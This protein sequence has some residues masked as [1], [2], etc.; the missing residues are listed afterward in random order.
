MRASPGSPARAV[1]A[2]H[3]VP[4]DVFDRVAHRWRTEIISRPSIGEYPVYDDNFY[5]YMLEDPV[6]MRAYENAIRHAAPGGVV[7][8]IGAGAQAPLS[9]MAA[10]A[11]A[12]KVYAIEAMPA[13]VLSARAH[14]ASLGLTDVIEVIHGLSTDVELPEPVDVCVSEI[15]GSIG[16]SEGSW[17]A[18]SD[19]R[20]F[21]QPHGSMLPQ[22]CRT[23]IA[24]A[25]FPAALYTDAEVERVT[26]HYTSAI[27]S[28]VGHRFEFTRNAVFNLPADHLLA[29]PDTFEILSF[30]A[31]H[32]TE[33]RRVA[34]F[35][36]ARSAP[37]DG[38]ALW[39]ELTVDHANVFSTFRGTSWVPIFLKT[40]RFVVYAGDELAVDCASATGANGHNPDYT[41]RGM[42]RRGSRIVHRFAIASPHI[43][44][45]LAADTL[46]A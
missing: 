46:A 1:P 40:P 16:S 3:Q 7:L 10:R 2:S 25:T 23:L 15:I 32:K 33:L 44:P 29:A 37:C 6:R 26:R 27:A 41:L 30:D 17:P 19:A 28:T 9:V 5:R 22:R 38:F 13:T 34:R 42:V 14:V 35:T 21:L 36:V 39:V 24:P 8:D 4:R 43:G 31:P 12:R 45:P 18:L 11:G 20:R